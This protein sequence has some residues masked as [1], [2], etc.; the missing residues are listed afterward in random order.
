[1]TLTHHGGMEI[2][3]LDRTQIVEVP[4]DPLTGLKSFVI[5]NALSELGA[6]GKSYRLWC[7]TFPSSG[8]CTI[9][10]V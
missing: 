9:T 5:S 1:M 2:E 4:F 8:I 7:K 10:T 6:P 3:E